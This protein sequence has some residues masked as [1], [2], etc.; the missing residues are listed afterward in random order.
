MAKKA[1]EIEK[2]KPEIVPE[3]TTEPKR[4]SPVRHHMPSERP[5]ITHKFRIGDDEGKGYVT[6]NTWEDGV[7]GEIFVRTNIMKRITRK[8]VVQLVIRRIKPLMSDTE[9]MLLDLEVE[10]VI[11]DQL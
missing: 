11:E 6:A 3:I 2:P 9:L 10:L 8:Q 4:P 5:G 7:V 1:E